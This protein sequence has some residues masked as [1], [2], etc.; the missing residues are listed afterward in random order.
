MHWWLEGRSP[1]IGR[2]KRAVS[3]GG[4]GLWMVGRI[5]ASGG[6]GGETRFDE[7][8]PQAALKHTNTKPNSSFLVTPTYR[9]GDVSGRRKCG[10]QRGRWFNSASLF[11]CCCC[12][13]SQRVLDRLCVFF[14]LRVEAEAVHVAGH[15]FPLQGEVLMGAGRVIRKWRERIRS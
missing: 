8:S 14:L 15:G 13:S 6:G 12:C 10:R 1:S 11:C 2:C 4:G 5:G 7:G 9:T 3:G